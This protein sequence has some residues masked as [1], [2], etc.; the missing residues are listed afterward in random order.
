MHRVHNGPPYDV[1]GVCRN[2]GC[3]APSYAKKLT[4]ASTS[5]S[6]SCAA[7][8]LSL[9]PMRAH[10]FACI[11]S[12]GCRQSAQPARVTWCGW[13]ERR[14]NS[15]TCRQPAE[16]TRQR[17]KHAWCMLQGAWCKVHGV[18]MRCQLASCEQPCR[19]ALLCF[20]LLCFALLCGTHVVVGC[21]RRQRIVE[22][23]SDERLGHIR[24]RRPKHHRLRRATDNMAV[25]GCAVWSS[26]SSDGS[27]CRV[28]AEHSQR[29]E[30]PSTGRTDEYRRA[31]SSII[32]PYDAAACAGVTPLATAAR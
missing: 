14:F 17:A 28:L 30:T 18:K 11:G 20:A 32:A 10:G 9:W 26:L 16:Y 3:F 25:T 19:F 24:Q 13:R 15:P 31:P 8:A 27:A 1:A 6:R 21:E 2:V 5:A 29:P 4:T 22:R 12:P 23:H 7:A